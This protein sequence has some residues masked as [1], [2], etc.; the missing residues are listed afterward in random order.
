MTRAA[1][2]ASVKASIAQYGA[3]GVDIDWEYPCSAARSDPVEISCSDFETVADAGGSCVTGGVDDTVNI[4]ALFSEMRAALGVPVPT[5]SD[6][7][8]KPIERSTRRFNPLVIPKALQAALPFKSK[9]KQD[10]PHGK[11]HKSLQVRL[12]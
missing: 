3:D 12:L 1:F 9:P 7:S 2:I 5:N 11:R 6:S 4:V 10:A 8:Y